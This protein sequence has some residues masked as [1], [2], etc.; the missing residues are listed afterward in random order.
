MVKDMLDNLWGRPALQ[1]LG[2][3][4]CCRDIRQSIFFASEKALVRST[5]ANTT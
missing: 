5:Y 4:C 1:C 3:P 2:S